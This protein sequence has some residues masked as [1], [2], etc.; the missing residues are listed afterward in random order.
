PVVLV[1][2]SGPYAPPMLRRLFADSGPWRVVAVVEGRRRNSGGPLHR[3]VG[4]SAGPIPS[5]NHLTT[6]ASAC[7]ITTL[8]TR[9]INDS[10]AI[11][12]ISATGARLL[13]CVGFDRLFAPAVLEAVPDGG[14]NIH[15]SLLPEWR[16]PAPLF[17]ALRE[18][19]SHIG[20]TVHALDPREDHGVIYATDHFR[21]PAR[22]SGEALYEA[23]VAAA[24][25]LLRRVLTAMSRGTLEG[26]RQ[27]D[28]NATRAP[29]PSFEDARVEPS[30]WK[31]EH[32]V[33]FVTGAT[34]F[35]VPW[36]QLG[37]ER[38]A[39]A[40]G[41]DAQPGDTIPGEFVLQRDTLIVQCADGVARLRVATR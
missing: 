20:M 15:P 27:D 36:M 19:R 14:I 40:S 32:L 22:A 34:F 23:S 10:R 11:D 33:D 13:L 17:W 12:F 16:G 24:Y 2:Q 18:G 37:G 38:F 30:R 3:R 7:G 35:C 9:D 31:C 8:Q 21:R 29:R 41:I 4:P 5:T 1:G 26:T 39:L 28:S 25:P 6:V